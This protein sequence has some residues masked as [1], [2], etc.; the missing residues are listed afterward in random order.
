MNCKIAC[1]AVTALFLSF[2]FIISGEMAESKGTAEITMTSPAPQ[3]SKESPLQI[4]VLSQT[5]T[6][7]E[8]E[9]TAVTDSDDEGYARDISKECFFNGHSGRRHN[10][11]DGTYIRDFQMGLQFGIRSLRITA[12]EGEMIGAIY[13]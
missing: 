13:I 11:T 2:L 3:A 7:A 4:S 10:L 12:P 6:A 8:T 1:R 9:M 5:E